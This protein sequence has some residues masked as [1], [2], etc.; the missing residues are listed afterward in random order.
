MTIWRKTLATL[1]EGRAL[2]GYFKPREMEAKVPGVLNWSF[3]RGAELEL[4]GDTTGWPEMGAPQFVV[5]GWLRQGVQVSLLH[6]WVKR[7]TMATQ[8]IALQSSTLALGEHMDH[9]TCWPQAIY[10]TANLSEWRRD[11]GLTYSRPAP[12]VRPKHVRVEWQPPSLDDVKVRGARMT[13]GGESHYSV[14]YAADWSIATWQDLVV[15]PEQPI[16]LADGWRRFASPLL[17]LMSFASDRPDCIGREILVD[18]ERNRRVE[19]WRQGRTVLPR[20]WELI[21]GYLFHAEDLSDYASAIDMWWTLDEKLR[22][23]LGLFADHINHGTSYSPARFLT[24]YTAM[25][26]YAK[27]RHGRNQVRLLRQFAGVSQTA[28]GCTD[29]ALRLIGASRR[30]FAHLGT[31]PNGPTVD[32]IEA[33]VV[34][35]TRRASALMQACLLRELRFS[36]GEIEKVLNTYY[37]RW[38]LS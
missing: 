31:Q 27:E 13:F 36:T 11:T 1:R 26:A 8:V 37:S 38:P 30:Y 25:E 10:S 2:P 3:E 16:T 9:G 20:E 35:S 23:A 32:E 12:K 22:P 6:T 33:N 14:A 28:T 19:I 15:N 18:P 4:I 24:L 21:G 29:E 7:T 5:H 17:N 34:L